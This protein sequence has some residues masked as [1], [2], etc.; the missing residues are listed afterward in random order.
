MRSLTSLDVPDLETWRPS[1]ESFSLSLRLLAGPDSGPGE[2]SFDIIVCSAEWIT[3]RVR[4]DEIYDARHHLIVSDFHWPAIS[5]YVGRRVTE[6][7]G[8][9]WTEVAEKVARLGHWEFED[10]EP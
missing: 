5:A 3:E 4:Q 8:D 1:G 7:Q 2:E 6:C 9:T 10:Y